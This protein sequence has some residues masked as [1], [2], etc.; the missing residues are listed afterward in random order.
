MVDTIIGALE[1]VVCVWGM[2]IIVLR[3]TASDHGEDA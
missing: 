3:F 1:A 2:G